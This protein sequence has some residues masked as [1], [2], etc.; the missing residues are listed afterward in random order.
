MCENRDSGVPVNILT[1]FA[2]VS[3]S[4]AAQH[5]TLCLMKNAIRYI[6]CKHNLISTNSHYAKFAMEFSAN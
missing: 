2:R 5:T 6:I 1:L 3:I 4:W